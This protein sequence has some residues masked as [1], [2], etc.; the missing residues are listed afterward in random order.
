MCLFWGNF[1]LFQ[2]NAG[3]SGVLRADVA[4]VAGSLHE[5]DVFLDHRQLFEN[6]HT[7]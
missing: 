1:D 2:K 4:D 6:I 7:H 3:H 5:G